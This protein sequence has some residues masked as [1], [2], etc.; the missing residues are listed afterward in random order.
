MK[1]GLT[2]LFWYVV[3]CFC[4]EGL[5]VWNINILNIF[6]PPSHCQAVQ[7]ELVFVSLTASLQMQLKLNGKLLLQ[8]WLLLYW[9][10]LHFIQTTI[11]S[12]LFLWTNDDWNVEIIPLFESD[13]LEQ[14]AFKMYGNVG[15]EGQ[16][17][18][19]LL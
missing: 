7:G 8:L 13:V 12:L 16:D 18:W 10:V 17:Y 11:D 19:P 4:P 9:G 2:G 15:L 1:I 14:E 5:P 6:A 3:V